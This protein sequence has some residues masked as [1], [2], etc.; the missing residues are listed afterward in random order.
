MSTLNRFK[1]ERALPIR[2][3]T[4][5][6]GYGRR[7]VFPMKRLPVTISTIHAG[8]GAG[9][10]VSVLIPANSWAEG[11]LLMVKAFYE[12]VK[13]G[14]G[15][16][17][18]WNIV[19]SIATD[20]SLAL[21][22]PGP[23]AYVPVAGLF[24]TFIQRNIIRLDPDLWMMDLGDTMLFSFANDDDNNQHIGPVAAAVPPFD[25]TIPMTVTLNFTVPAT[26]PGAFIKCFWAEAFQI[27]RA[28][29]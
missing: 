23:G 16:F 10:L 15:P 5:S 12:L 14:P 4:H 18:A 25:F 7:S 21:V 28:H 13:P 3:R 17:P 20:Q 1:Y 19:E 11:K 2:D 24:S 29:V 8:A 22:L 9:P 6:P 26:V 27:G